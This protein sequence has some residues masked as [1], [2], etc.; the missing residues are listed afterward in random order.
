M[1]G[2]YSGGQSHQRQPLL[3]T[4]TIPLMTRRSSARSTPRTSVGKCG[5]IRSHCSSLSQNRFLR[6]A[7]SPKD[8]SRRMESEL[9]WLGSRLMSSHPS[10]MADFLELSKFVLKEYGS[11]I[12]SGLGLFATV[13]FGGNFFYQL[14]RHR[15]SHLEQQLDAERK[16]AEQ[17]RHELKTSQNSLAEI[18]KDRNGSRSKLA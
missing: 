2:P 18:E 12:I 3:S 8:E 13:A 14:V 16:A 15:I 7:R 6:T 11:L 9:S 4:C 10:H 1:C 5:S 17:T